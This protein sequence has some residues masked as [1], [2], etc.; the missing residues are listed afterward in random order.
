MPRDPKPRS[1]VLAGTLEMLI[2]RTLTLGSLHG[3]AIAQHIARLSDGVLQV[4]Q[5]SLYP[6]LERVLNKGW[7]TAEWGES[8]TKRQARYYTI[9]KSGRAQL[10]EKASE[11]D[12]VAGAIARIMGRA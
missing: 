5:G 11:Y 4:E 9:T 1:D 2:L 8:P 3:Y 10:K 12:R 6:A 7:A